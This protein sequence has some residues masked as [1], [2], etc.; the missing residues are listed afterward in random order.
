[1]GL[2]DLIYKKPKTYQAVANEAA[3]KSEKKELNWWFLD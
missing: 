2:S 3:T 1:M